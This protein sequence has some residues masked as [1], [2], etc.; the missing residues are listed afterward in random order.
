MYS[1]LYKLGPGQI[2]PA[3]GKSSVSSEL[4]QNN[5]IAVIDKVK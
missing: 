4:F 2:T 5:Y 3:N 1:C